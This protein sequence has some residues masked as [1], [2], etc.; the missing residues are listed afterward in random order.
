MKVR[1]KLLRWMSRWRL[2]N[3]RRAC[4]LH[5]FDADAEDIGKKS[6]VKEEY[7]QGLMDCCVENEDSELCVSQSNYVK[8]GVC[9][10]FSVVGE[11][12]Y[13]SKVSGALWGVMMA[14][15]WV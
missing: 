14:N 3:G 13:T 9:K 7:G 10:S 15:V 12:P 6:I 8:E 4:V 5:V 1:V 2:Y 11:R